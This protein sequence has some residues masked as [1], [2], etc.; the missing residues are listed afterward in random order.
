MPSCVFHCGLNDYEWND[1]SIT[2]PMNS[3]NT[4]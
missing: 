2:V 3:Q 4:A 1:T